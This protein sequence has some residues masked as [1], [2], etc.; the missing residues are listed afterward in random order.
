MRRSLALVA[1][2]LVMAS[3]AVG[4]D[5]PLSETAGNL[6]EINSGVMKVELTATASD[7]DGEART[8]FI[9]EGP[10]ALPQEDELPITNLEYTQIAGEESDVT[11]FISTADAGYVVVD[12]QAY[13]LPA[14]QLEPLRGTG[15]TTEDIFG[16]TDFSSWLAEPT[17]EEGPAI[18]G[19]PTD[20]VSGDLDVVAAL[21]DI[22]AVARHFGADETTFPIIEGDDAEHLA[23]AVESAHL[24]LTTGHE[25]R[26]M[27]DLEVEIR[28]DVQHQQEL[29]EILGSM[30][31]VGFSF[32]MEIQDPNEPV[33]VEPPSDPLPITE[34]N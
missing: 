17:T 19:A 4:S 29:A 14:E 25:D 2:A 31:G 21:N 30:A 1:V 8:G 15:E 18:D 22:F 27:R 6:D 32:H 12:E 20:V 13:E 3:C 33:V 23:N 26:L 7:T 11:G 28:F 16:E 34:L 5:D 10:F 24:S 9:L